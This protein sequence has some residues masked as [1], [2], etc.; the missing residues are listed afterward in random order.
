[1]THAK[2]RSPRNCSRKPAA[3]PL[4]NPALKVT[5][6]V[7]SGMNRYLQVV[8]TAEPD[9]E[10]GDIIEREGVR[11]RVLR[12]TRCPSPFAEADVMIISAPLVYFVA[13]E[14]AGI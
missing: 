5:A 2:R 12:I 10:I 14:L 3:T 6:I 1:M 8:V 11:W 4:N 9:Y 7:E 13:L